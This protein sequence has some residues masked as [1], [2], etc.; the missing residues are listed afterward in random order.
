M[1]TIRPTINIPVFVSSFDM[2]LPYCTKTHALAN[3]LNIITEQSVIPIN[4]K[5]F[6]IASIRCYLKKLLFNNG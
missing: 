3:R 4:I 5:K 1:P 6:L 2:K